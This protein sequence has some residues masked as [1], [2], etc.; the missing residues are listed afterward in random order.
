MGNTE[1]RTKNAFRACHYCVMMS[2][3]DVI[4]ERLLFFTVR[5]HVSPSDGDQN[6]MRDY[7]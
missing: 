7:E 3:C 1:V 6:M 5:R 2:V 4:E